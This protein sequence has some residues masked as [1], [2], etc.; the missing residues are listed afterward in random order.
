[1]PPTGQIADRLFIS[2]KTVSVHVTN[3]LA[4]LGVPNR[5][6]AA[7][8]ARELARRLTRQ[9]ESEPSRRHLELQKPL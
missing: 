8:L 5:G 1:M 3:V 7:A 2:E 4:K 6:A 9:L